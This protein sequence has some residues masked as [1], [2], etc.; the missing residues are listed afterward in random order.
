[1]GLYKFSIA[2]AASPSDIETKI[3]SVR[4]QGANIYLHSIVDIG[5][6]NLSINNKNVTIN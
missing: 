3:T 6:L 4:G 5:N 1:M 2:A